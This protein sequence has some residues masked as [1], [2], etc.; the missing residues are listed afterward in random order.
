MRRRESIFAPEAEGFAAGGN[1]RARGGDSKLACIAIMTLGFGDLLKD[2]QPANPKRTLEIMDI[3]EVFADCFGVHNVE[4]QHSHLPSTEEAWLKEFRIRLQ[5]T[6]SRVSNINLEFNPLS[7]TAADVDAAAF[8]AAL[9]PGP[10]T[11]LGAVARLQAIDLT[12]QWIDH[13]A[14]LECPRVMVNQGR[15]TEQNKKTAIASLKTMVD[16]AKRK[17]IMVSIEPRVGDLELLVE[18]M[19]GAGA[20]ANL[21]VGNFGDE[22]ST[23]SGIKMMLPLSDGNCHVKYNPAR[24]DLPK[25]L[26]L[27]KQLGYRGLYSIETMPFT[28]GIPPEVS[29]MPASDPYKG[30]REVIDIVLANIWEGAPDPAMP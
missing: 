7:V 1:S 10:F 19:K 26:A 18:I 16:Y 20:Y 11:T 12:K 9:G 13:A 8:P 14:I 25:S 30:V 4:L 23:I 5:K 6:K 21:D 22:V 3:G 28:P 17:N 29:C 15:P 24:F 2:N 27:L